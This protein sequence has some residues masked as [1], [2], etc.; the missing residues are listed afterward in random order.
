MSK[1][2]KLIMAALLLAGLA[3][4]PGSTTAQTS[5][6]G[7]VEGV[8][9][10]AA[11]AVVPNATV[12]LSGP[13]LVRP[14]TTSADEN[15][16]YRFLQVPPGRYT[17]KVDAAAGFGAFE[18]SNVE[19]NLSKSTQ[20]NISLGAQGVSGTVDVTASTP[21]IDQNTNTTG[22]NISTDFFSNIPTSRT[23]QG[24]YTIAPTVARSGL[25]D[26][27]G[28]E[29]DPSVAGSSGPENNYILDGVNT[30]DPAFGG[31]G[32]NLPFEFIQEVEI[33]TG[34]FG[35]DQGLSTGGVFNVI[36]KSGG[37][38]YHGDIFAYGL[39]QSFVR[40]TK[41]FPFTGLAPN[42]YSELDAGVDIGGPIIKNRL[43]FFAAFNPQFRTNH[44]LTQT[45][46]QEVEGKIKTPFYSGK[47]SWFINDR[48][49]ATFSTFG[50]FTK[51]KGHLYGQNLQTVA[52]FGVDEGAFQGIR[53]TG[54]QNYAARL[55]SNIRQN[56][57]GEFAFG[58]HKQR[59][60][61]IPATAL[62][63][64]LVTD[65]F[66][67]LRAD[68]TV[69]PIVQTGVQGITRTGFV[70]YAY[71]PGGT[72]QRNFVQTDGFGLYQTQSRDRWEAAARFQNIFDQHTFKYGFEFYRN[73]YDIVQDSTGPNNVYANPL[74]V[75]NNNGTDIDNRTVTG[76]RVTNN[77]EVC[78]IRASAV[79]CPLNENIA[80][81][82][83]VLRSFAAQNLAALQAA[84]GALPGG[85]TSIQVGAVT[86]AEL[87]N[88]PVLVRLTT[89]VRDFALNAQ[90][91]TDVKSWYFQDDWRVTRNLQ[92]NIGARWDFQTAR[93]ANGQTY[94]DLNNWFDN[95]QPRLGF[96]WDPFGKGTTKI[97]A[98][99]ARFVETPLPLDLNVRAGGG[100]SQTDKNFNVNR[101]NA[102]LNSTV[103]TNFNTRNLGADPTPI[104][105]GL[106]P[107]SV[108]EWTAGF[109]HQ[110]MNSLTFGFRGIYRAQGSVIEDGS[111]DD[112][113]TYFL[114]NPGEAI[115]PRG[116]QFGNTEFIAGTPPC[117]D[118]DGDGDPTNEPG[119]GFTCG[120]VG[121]G[122][123]RARR[124]YRGLE[125]T[126]NRR[127]ADHFS[128][129]S[130]YVFSSLIGNYEGLFRN[131]NGQ[132]D[133]NITSLFDI[134]SL[135]D[136]TYGRLPNDRPH[137]FKFNG[138]YETPLK[139]I[140]SG[141]LYIQSG[142]PFSQLVPHPVYGNN[143]GFGV[144]R[145]TAIIP[146]LGAINGN[147][148][149]GS[150]VG[151]NRTPTT[152]NLD[153]GAYYPW[154]I[155]ENMSLR[156]TADWFNV[157][158]TQRAVQLDQTALITLG[159]AGTPNVPNPFYGS[160]QV[161]QYPS[162]FRLGAKFTF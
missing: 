66:A 27:S 88:N 112:G 124:F 95:L 94:L 68:N 82:P 130:S 72:L 36:T 123:G 117:G 43:T 45:F 34:A 18:Q 105:A 92:F 7:S 104:D 11:G 74:N 107:Q 147:G 73:S 42:G 58:L 69:A 81:G 46:R 6:T 13:G 162:A 120:G 29:R 26:A 150:A 143:E 159:V 160:G 16:G 91:E 44:Y 5:T 48:N 17:V 126:L 28:R 50:D 85:A 90:T 3:A 106:K 8:V 134:V 154:K 77:F 80:A 158:N 137:Q 33:K 60:N 12:V 19:V 156:F 79:V 78:T 20:V 41:N 96:S 71:S 157:T 152:W 140:V 22:S 119:Y 136:N 139:L 153:L 93:D 51:E 135:L 52:G 121:S 53:E 111:F 142:V 30:T 122:F 15:G 75:G 55:N 129:N 118:S 84:G 38:E 31:G 108:N 83:G 155:N 102:P 138:S 127:F 39:P 21:E 100:G 57:I 14:Q 37:N 40:D 89:R 87:N 101:L 141:N 113:D 144:P 131:D 116:G 125:F 1:A 47:L 25:R 24:L 65:A 145:G 23:V 67:I 32:A 4:L 148:G 56:W 54:G 115:P 103:A 161:F 86:A 10:D 110:L 35:A 63:S 114:F 109:E 64:P 99:Y 49:T 146:D 98:N 62:D 97:F 59:N 9:T 132:A 149:I 133:P 76:F 70:D 61:L 128:F 2:V 151:T